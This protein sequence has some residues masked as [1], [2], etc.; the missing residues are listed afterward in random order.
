VKSSNH[1]ARKND[2]EDQKGVKRAKTFYKIELNN[3]FL[4]L[5]IENQPKGQKTPLLKEWILGATVEE[6]TSCLDQVQ[7]THVCISIP[8]LWFNF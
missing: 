3:S 6:T 2:K 1:Q 7:N 5:Q 4:P 8:L